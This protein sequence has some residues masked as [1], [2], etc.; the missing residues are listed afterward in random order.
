MAD[1]NDNMDLRLKGRLIAERF[2]E[3]ARRFR[4][5]ADC[6]EDPN[7]IE[8][9]TWKFFMPRD[10]GIC[11]VDAVK[12]GFLNE[13]DIVAYVEWME[14]KPHPR[15]PEPP[16]TAKATL[17]RC[18]A[19]VW[20]ALLGDGLVPFRIVD[21]KL[22]PTGEAPEPGPVARMFPSLLPPFDQA[23]LAIN[24]TNP[25]SQKAFLRAEAVESK[26]RQAWVCRAL[27]ELIRERAE[28][29][30][31]EQRHA[32]D[33]TAARTDRP[34]PSPAVRLAGESLGEVERAR[35]D[36]IPPADDPQRYTRAQ[37]EWIRENS[38]T[39]HNA[40]KHAPSYDTWRRYVREYLRLTDGQAT[41]PRPQGGRSNVHPDGSPTNPTG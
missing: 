33:E 13:P 37:W 15:L 7:K 40:E 34:A 38:E 5:W 16:P 21:G 12:A 23:A 39:Y 17:V 32:H 20:G 41:E 22:A 29:N 36:L 35:P 28:G 6:I 24:A 8:D 14:G 3:L 27:G 2:D 19:N 11:I 30:S 25:E 10:A 9:P 4:Q 18:E 31:A 26:H 1:R